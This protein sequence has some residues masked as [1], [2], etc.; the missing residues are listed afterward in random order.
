[1]QP[2]ELF[3]IEAPNMPAE[4]DSRYNNYM[5]LSLIDKLKLL[6][7]LNTAANA[8]QEGI[9]MKDVT[10]VIVAIVALITG[11]LQ[12]PSINATIVAAITAHPAVAAGL[13]GLSAVLALLHNPNTQKAGDSKGSSQAGIVPMILLFLLIFPASLARAQEQA[14]AATPPADGNNIY[15]VGMNYSVNSH[16]G[17]AGSLLYARLAVPSTDTWL[18]TNGDFVPNTLKPF[19]VTNNIGA[20]VAQK[21]FT[22]GNVPVFCVTGAGVSWTGTNTGFQFNGGCMATIKYKGFLI[23]PSGRFLKSS[24]SNGTAYQPIIGGYI[25][26]RF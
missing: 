24:V 23:M 3:T 25:G 15:A 12:I 5:K 19:T 21:I 22:L 1:M 16:P 2:R 7:K 11:I 4:I 20:G 26:K 13:A 9:N 6:G 18:F 8:V 10:K 17:L 14:P